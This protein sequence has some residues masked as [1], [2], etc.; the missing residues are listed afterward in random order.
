MSFCGFLT[1]PEVARMCRMS[2]R[3][4][5]ELAAAGDLKSAKP[6]GRLLIYKS[7]VAEK[8]GCSVEE[9]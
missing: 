7:A 4:V 1:V 5:Q 3:R 6:F 8:I 2:K 9:L